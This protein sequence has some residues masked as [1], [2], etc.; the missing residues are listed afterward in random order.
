M[1]NS[2]ISCQGQE[3]SENLVSGQINIFSK[4]RRLLTVL[5]NMVNKFNKLIKLQCDY[6]KRA[7]LKKTFLVSREVRTL[8]VSNFVVELLSV[9]FN[10]IGQ[11]T[12]KVAIFCSQLTF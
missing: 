7:S 3:K 1:G 8:L 9:C 6:L 4:A 2:K 10:A 12:K 11:F 5:F